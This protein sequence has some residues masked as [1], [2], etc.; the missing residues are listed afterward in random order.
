MTI[1]ND[2]SYKQQIIDMT[3]WND[4]SYKQEFIDMAIHRHANS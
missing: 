4:N 3:I 2:N 1:W